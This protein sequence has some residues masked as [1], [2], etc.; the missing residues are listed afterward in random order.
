MKMKV[1]LLLMVGAISVQAEFVPMFNGKDFT[2]WGAP[3]KTEK[4]GYVVEGEMI[5]TAPPCS[6]LVTDKEYED[7]IMEF[8]FQLT[9]GANNGLGIH[10]PGSGDAAYKGMELQILDGEN[11]KYGGKLKDYQHHGSLYTLAPALRGHMKPIGEWNQQ[12]VT[13]RGPRV[14]VELNGVCILD[15]NLDELNKTHPNHEGAKRRKGKICFAGHGDVIRLKNLR[16]AELSHGT[17]SEEA[18]YQAPGKADETLA[19]K[20][21]APLFDGKSLEGWVHAAGDLNH[22]APKD[23]WVL[24]Y[25][26][27]SEA[28][29]K[30]LWTEKEYKDFVL[31]CDWRWAGEGPKMQRPIILPNGEV[32]IGG[33]GKPVM[34]EIAEFD[35]GVYLRGNP[36]TQINMWE[37]PVGSG[38]VFGVRTDGKVPLDVRAGVTPRVN[39]DKP[40]GEW[41][42]FVMT[43]KGERVTV[44][45]NGKTVLHEALLPGVKETGRLALQHHGSEMEFANL[46]VKEM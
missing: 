42:R 5:V 25:D 20:G 36:R 16:I 33:D 43:M 10:Y 17:D 4:N 44:V 23:G 6:N 2:G 39:A 32:R 3:G 38:E 40:V 15:A 14:S 9:P 7:Y 37:W 46:F 29:D 11:E 21:F 30:N 24:H 34:E 28:K 26:G 31:I 19:E 35:S 12:R 13:V 22:W 1:V 41:N 18:L 8:E 45:L 27:K